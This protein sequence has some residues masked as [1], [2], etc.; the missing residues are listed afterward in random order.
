MR[1]TRAGELRHRVAI[2]ELTV[3][4]KDSGGSTKAWTEVARRWMNIRPMQGTELAEARQVVGN[5]THKV[6]MRYYDGLTAKKHRLV[7]GT[8]TFQIAAV[9]NVEE[10]G[11]QME[12]VCEEA[13]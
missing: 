11:V 6:R 2:E 7:F 4:V 10:R 13:V 12:L 9:V 1:P 8:R 5:V 3:T